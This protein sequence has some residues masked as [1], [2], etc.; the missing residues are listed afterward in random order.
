MEIEGHCAPRFAAV[1][2]EF[3]K[4]FTERSD[5]AAAVAVYHD[6]ELVVDLHG[7]GWRPGS[8]VNVFSTTKGMTALCAHMLADRGLL[9]I[10]APVA[11]YWPEFAQAGKGDVPVRWLLSHRAGLNAF[12]EPISREDLYAWHP[13][14]AALAAAAP[15]WTP[16][17]R[18]A[19]HALTFGF[20]VGEVIRRVSGKTVAAF[21]R[22]EVAGVLGDVEFYIGLRDS[23]HTRVVDVTGKSTGLPAPPEPDPSVA[24]MITN[25][26]KIEPRFVNSPGWRR[27]EL[28]AGN[29]H[30]DAKSLARV[31]HALAL[32]GALAG[33]RL[34]SAQA[35]ERMREPQPEGVDGYIGQIS[36]GGAM[37]WR[38][39]FM[40]NLGQYGPSQESFGHTG[41]GGSFA[42]CHPEARLSIAYVTSALVI[43]ELDVRG[44]MLA[45]AAYQG[46]D[47]A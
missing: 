3:E 7:G 44:A 39:G 28:P 16:G 31:Y 26:P 23:L 37:S 9:D 4:N 5:G 45:Y 38:L 14:C 19:Y 10:D 27:A 2:A 40:P 17:S 22:D 29:G 43:G 8:I 34:V 24:A 30:G 6:G 42:M 32:G 46:I 20:L 36:G 25:Q 13:A 33:R 12:R 47:A 41:F 18:S 21:F 15:W 11:R 1:R 35:V